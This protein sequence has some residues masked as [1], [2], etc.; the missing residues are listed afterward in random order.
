MKKLYK[1][2]KNKGC[3]VILE[4]DGG[5]EIFGGYDYNVFSY[6]KDKFANKKNY[7]LK[8]FDSLKNL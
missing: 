3:R 6:L 2:A 1:L 5:D 8:I 7:Q 4:G